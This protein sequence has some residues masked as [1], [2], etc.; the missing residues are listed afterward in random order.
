MNCDN[1]DD[2]VTVNATGTVGGDLNT[3]GGEDAV[4][5]DIGAVNGDVNTGGANDTVDV[6]NG[7]TVGGTIRTGDGDDTIEID[8]GEVGGNV[9]A[10]DGD[11]Q[12]T[13]D[14]SEVG[15]NVVTGSGTDTI[16]IEETEIGGNINSGDG[17]DTVNLDEEAEITGNVITDGGDDIINI[18]GAE[19]GGNLNTG[20]GADTV[21][22]NAGGEVE[23][24]VTTDG[25]N[26]ILTLNNGGEVG[27]NIQMGDDDDRLNINGGEVGGD[28]LTGG[29]VDVVRIILSGSNTLEFE[30][31]QLNTG[32]GDDSVLLRGLSNIEEDDENFEIENPDFVFR[33]GS[34]YDVFRADDNDDGLKLGAIEGFE[35]LLVEESILVLTADDYMFSPA[36]SATG[37]IE[38]DGSSQLW[39]NNAATVET[40]HIEIEAGGMLM[41]GAFPAGEGDDDDDEG[42]EAGE[43]VNTVLNIGDSTLVNNG[44]VGTLNG[45]VGDTVTVN[46]GPYIAASATAKMVIDT[47]LGGSN[48]PTDRFNFTYAG[49]GGPVQGNTTTVTVNNVGGIGAFTGQ[50]PTDGIVIVS[51][52]AGF[53]P[54]AFQLGVNQLTGKQEVLA[55]AF[56]YRLFNSPTAALLQSDIL[57][58]VPGYA[59]VSSVAQR[60]AS[61]GLGTLY[62]RM[63]EVR[64]GRGDGKTI[65]NAGA[66]MWVRGFYNDSDVSPEAGFAFSQ[67]NQGVMGGADIDLGSSAGGHFLAG[68]FGGY[69]TADAG[70]SATIWGVKS[71]STV[72]LTAYTFGFYGSYYDVGR[73]GTGLYVD[74]VFK[75]DIT[76]F[77]IASAA[78]AASASTDGYTSTVSGETGYG[79]NLGGNLTLLPQAQLS[80]ISVSNQNYQD[81]YGVKVG[82]G[83]GESLVGRASLQLQGNYGSAS[84][85][86]FAPYAIASILSDFLGDNETAIGRTPFKNDMGLTWYE[87]GGGVTAELGEFVSLYGSAE[88]SFGDIEGWGGTGGVKARW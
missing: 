78:R 21:T 86:W 29:G 51:A 34:G 14:D 2:D 17:N 71:P 37:G 20:T 5:I 15:G 74:G 66:G 53:A 59:I 85:G 60:Y 39:F 32:A 56:S 16:T 47:Q 65:G 88:Y 44:T 64:L 87:A 10:G 11:N 4:T 18:N 61:A 43:P 69:G 50:G 24:N 63:G 9:N 82:S 6:I 28:I 67:K 79:F 81:N 3:D 19:V 62:K 57:D 48:S 52:P 35:T 27:G 31:T 58:Q 33:G 41:F 36:S 40:P 42:G 30:G 75:V 22:I 1:A 45:I 49:A 46:G 70:T 68:A 12:I 76:D 8:D 25:G 7:G 84:G 73:P 80:Y 26:D 38:I 23:G 77:E 55:G 72:D 83:V 13:I 54:T